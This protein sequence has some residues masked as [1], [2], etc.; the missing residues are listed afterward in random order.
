[1]KTYVVFVDVPSYRNSFRAKTVTKRFQLPARTV[2]EACDTALSKVKEK[3]FSD[4]KISMFWS[5]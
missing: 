3:G 2:S 1:M 4:A 5:I